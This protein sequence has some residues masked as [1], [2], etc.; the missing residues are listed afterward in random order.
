MALIDS[1]AQAIG[2]MEGF[3]SPGTIARANNNPGNLRSWG[4]LPTAN[5]YAV[6]PTEQA[7]WDALKL[8]IQKNIDRGLTLQEFFAGQ[9]DENGNVIP[10]GYS[11]YSS[12]ADRNDPYRYADFVAGRL[13]IDPTAP[14]SQSL[15]DLSD[16]GSSSDELDTTPTESGTIDSTQIF[17]LAGI[18]LIVAGIMMFRD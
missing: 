10:G 11:G 9:R 18:A 7:G 8:Q 14:I 16:G 4:N 6:F 1:F 5:G 2:Q 3:N 17:I 12:S 13:G 15:S